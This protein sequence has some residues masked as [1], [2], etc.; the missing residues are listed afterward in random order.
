MIAVGVARP[1]AHGQAMT[2]TEMNAVRAR[3]RRGSGPPMNQMAKVSAPIELDRHEHRADPVGQLLDRRLAALGTLDELDDPGQGR[4]AADPGGPHDERAAGVERRADGL[5]AG[6]LVD[7]HRFTGQHRLVDRRGPFDEHAVD[8]HLLAGPD[9]QQVPRLYLIERDV[10][11]LVP[12]DEA[13]GLGLQP[14]EA[15]DGAGRLAPRTEL[16]PSP[17]EHEA[18]DDGRGVEIGLGVEPGLVDDLRPHRDEDRIRPGRGRADDDE[19]VHRRPAVPEG[20]PGRAI[21]A[22]AG[23]ELDEGRR[24]QDELVQVGHRDRG[25]RPEHQDHDHDGG[26]DRDDRLDQHQTQVAGADGIFLGLRRAI[27]SASLPSVPTVATRAL[28]RTS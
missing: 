14:D 25:L 5:V 8:G 21:E 26:G 4:L 2:T 28:G 15:L 3:V 22:P 16:E 9:P 18:D 7:G 13:G 23:P 1:I 24:P 6:H 12:P 19:G 17:E 10:E 20:P 11:L 27:A